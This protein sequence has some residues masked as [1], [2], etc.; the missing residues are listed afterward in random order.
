VAHLDGSG[1]PQLS[2]FRNDLTPVPPGD[3]RLVLRNVAFTP[4]L[5]VMLDGQGR[6]TGFTPMSQERAVLP[7]RTYS[8]SMAAD[9]GTAIGPMPLRLSSLARGSD[10]DAS[11]GPDRSGAGARTGPD[12]SPDHF[13]AQDGLPPPPPI[14]RLAGGSLFSPSRSPSRSVFRGHRPPID[15][16]SRVCAAW[17]NAR[18]LSRHLAPVT[19]H[20]TEE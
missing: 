3:C 15:S 10:L 12:H 7:A 11:H 17:A 20:Q 9:D 2:L 14:P 5:R 1:Q 4:A 8:I 19:C 13:A 6:F 16:G 18:A